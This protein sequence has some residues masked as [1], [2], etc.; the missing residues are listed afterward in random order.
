MSVLDRK[1]LRD[2]FRLWAQVLAIALVMA[3]GV[4]T[5]ILAIGAYRSLEETR[6]AFYD[7]Y[8]FAT[9][10]SGLTRAPLQIK[11][12]LASISG[13]SGI[14][15]RIVKPVLLDMPGMAEPATGIA[16]S[17]PDHGEPAVNRLYLRSGRLP[18]PGR[19][20]EIAVTEPFALAHRMVPGSRFDAIMNGR[21]RTLVVTGIVLSPE[22]IYAI[23]PGDMIPDQRRFGVFFMPRAA[24]AGIF[25]MEGAFN[26]VALRT[27]RNADLSEII[28]TLD[29]VLGP[30]GGTGA[31]DR[32]DQ[33]SH[34]FL[35][36]ELAQLRAMA[37]V[38][39][40]VF[41]FVSAF[42]VNMILTRL[43]ALEREQV[44]LMKAVGYGSAAIAWHYAKLT[45]VIALIGIVIGSIAGDW[46][47]RGMT[48][49]YAQ[50]YSFPFLIFRQS[51]DLYEIAAIVSA[52]A[53][54]AG[55]MR[56]IWSVASLPPAIAMQPPTPTRY[57]SFFSEGAHHLRIFSQLTIMALRHLVRWPVRT[58]L[59][60]FGTSLAVALLIMALFSFDSVAFMV[61]TVF[62]RTERQDATIAFANERSPRAL[63]S[64]AAMPGVLRAEGFRATPVILRYGHRE[65]RLTI[66][67]MME[68]PDL[69]RMLDKALDPV[70]PAPVGLMISEWVA[71][72]LHLQVG[73]IAEV[74]LLERAHRKVAV[75]VSA[76]VE[77]YVG[78]AVYMR[79]DAL[80]RVIGDGPRLSGVRV[81]IDSSRLDDLYTTIKETPAV[82]AIALQGL[83]RQRFRET[84]EK[85]ITI[86]TSVYTALAV[87]IT[88]GV[89][90]NSARIQFSERA[91]E[92][93]SLR[94]FGFTNG[95]VSSVLLIELG[96][97]VLL[98][99]PLGWLLGYLL[100]WSVVR[101]FESDLFRVPFV[102]NRS[103]FAIASLI[104]VTVAAISALIVR[105]RIDRL[106][107]VRVLKTRE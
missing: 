73:D 9:V 15:L 99:Q 34:T 60:A 46:L 79:A 37:A 4:A 16:V 88:F 30:Y 35:D 3:C 58:L 43:I 27:Q 75:P 68:N 72:L 82:A 33:I 20:G 77:S 54:L 90:Y 71:K 55:S 102:I 85:N 66:S 86:M 11:N 28:D 2:L 70:E 13:V 12:E 21:K 81:K 74:E 26:D 38:I 45:L 8:R 41:L 42:L 31:H 63:Q 19:T 22:Y 36:E 104:V 76:I 29:A 47:G 52:V 40:P 25:D 92:L 57:R 17:I 6:S 107:L 94:V 1:L 97:M 14:E 62:F 5:I 18:E 49:L 24:L 96:A 44:G 48:R 65:R 100:S 56:S 98:A 80:D 91:R 78:L 95:E 83:S 50:F 69:A 89:V 101:G 64:V 103:T 59:T 51:L 105:R 10:F 67:G 32:T 23:G 106:D 93:A 7:R 61:D 84:I 53:A 39:P 87:I